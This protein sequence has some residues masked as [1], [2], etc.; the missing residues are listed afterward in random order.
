MYICTHRAR[1]CPVLPAADSSTIYEALISYELG[2]MYSWKRE[3]QLPSSRKGLSPGT[4]L[5]G[6]RGNAPSSEKFS[7]FCPQ[8][9]ISLEVYLRT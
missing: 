6:A 2:F 8:L 9:V 7:W 1:K 3:A 5:R 4:Y